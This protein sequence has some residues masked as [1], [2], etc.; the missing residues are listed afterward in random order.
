MFTITLPSY[1]QDGASEFYQSIIQSQCSIVLILAIIIAFFLFKNGKLNSTIQE[2]G[3]LLVIL[4]NIHL[5][6]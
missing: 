3:L 1:S 4:S 5:N 6:R 2:V